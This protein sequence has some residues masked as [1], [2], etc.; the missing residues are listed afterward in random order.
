MLIHSGVGTCV[1]LLNSAMIQQLPCSL[2]VDTI[3]CIWTLQK[4]SILDSI[5][6]EGTE[7]NEEIKQCMTLS[8]GLVRMQ[9]GFYVNVEH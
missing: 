8:E 4:D 2:E 9:Q 6:D 7:K 3:L 1:L 5:L